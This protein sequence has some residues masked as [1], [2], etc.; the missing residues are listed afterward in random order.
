MHRLATTPAV[1]REAEHDDGDDVID[2]WVDSK[3]GWISNWAAPRS[4]I[5]ALIGEA[6]EHWGRSAT[7]ETGP[8][9]QPG[10][11]GPTK[12]ELFQVL[13]QSGGETRGSSDKWLEPFARA[14][15]ARWG[16]AA[17]KPVPV[18]ERL[19]GPED[20]CVNPRNGQGQW[21]WGWVQHDP[22]L[23]S[24]RWRMMPREWLTDEALAWAP[25]WAF[26]VPTADKGEVA[27]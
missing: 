10:A 18:S 23:Y 17:V 11:E 19:P 22:V 14:V 26:P 13:M 6:L 15:L 5:A 4:D 21:C 27:A 16:G 7:R 20:C 25:W 9:P 12:A 3:S 2:R 1:T 8:A 24:G